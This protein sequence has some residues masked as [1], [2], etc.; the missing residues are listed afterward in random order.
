MKIDPAK[1]T[2]DAQELLTITAL[3]HEGIGIASRQ[4]GK[5]VFVLGALPG[6][7]ATVKT[8]KRHRRYEEAVVLELKQTSPQRIQP[9]CPHFGLCGGCQL[10][11]ISHSAQIKFKQDTL[12]SLLIQ[13]S[14]L[15]IADSLWATPLI[16]DTSG[17]RRKARIGVKWDAKKNTMYVGFRERASNKLAM[18]NV[19]PILFPAVGQ[20]FEAIKSLISSL[21]IKD[22]IPQIEM[23]VGEGSSP[24]AS[25]KVALVFRHLK[26]LLPE[27]LDLLKKFGEEHQFSIY[28]QPGKPGSVY[29]LYPIETTPEDPRNLL[30]YSVE[31]ENQKLNFDFHPLD[32]TQIHS[33][34][35]QKM[36]NQALAWLKLK[37]TDTVID[38]FCGLG[39]F[40]LALALKAQKVIGVEGEAKLIEKAKYNAAKNQLSDK[41]EFHIANLFDT[42]ILESSQTWIQAVDVLLIDP[43]RSGAKEVCERIERWAPT[44]ILYISCSPASFARDAG[45]LLNE[46]N[47]ELTHIGIMDMF[48]HTHHIETM[49]LFTLKGHKRG[50]NGQNKGRP[51]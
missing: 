33:G 47:Y 16:S 30:T 41:A 22:A 32:F 23:A 18:L 10:Q 37:N 45:I 7:I 21:S 31:I 20:R 42:K 2:Q 29:Q 49:A 1:I 48:P 11:H 51:A 44:Q 40:T 14:Q 38:L 24:D 35:N 8:M 9:H 12:K 4:D 36:I 13:I 3:T 19:C 6:E 43:P 46:K 28:L 39:N 27:D 50:K 26:D 17:Y 34:I 5:K 25:N 15:E